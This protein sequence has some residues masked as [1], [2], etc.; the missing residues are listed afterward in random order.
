MVDD[1][2]TLK[3]MVGSFMESYAQR[4]KET[5]FSVWLG[6]R[7]RREMPE[8]PEG[9]EQKLVKEIVAA[10]AD[11]DKTLAEL[12]EAM[13]AGMSKEEWFA[14]RM[15][16]DSAGMKYD[17]VGEKLLQIEHGLTASDMQLMQ[18]MDGTQQCA[19]YAGHMLL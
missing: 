15:A 12:D 2:R 4:D 3:S 18:E 1:E 8:L 19:V 10:V 17:N 13:D 11:Y 14:E 7:L 6:D 5:D 16:E 9:S